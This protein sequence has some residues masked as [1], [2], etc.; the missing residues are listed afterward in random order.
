MNFFIQSSIDLDTSIIRSSVK[1][2]DDLT[3]D[4]YGGDIEHWLTRVLGIYATLAR[5]TNHSQITLANEAAFLLVYE[6]SVRQIRSTLSDEDAITHERFRPNFVV[7]KETNHTYPAAYSEDAW[8]RLSM[9]Y[10]DK[11]IEWTTIGSCQRC[12]V[13]NIDPQTGN[14]RSRLFTRLQTQR[15]PVHQIRAN[16]GILLSLSTNSNTVIVRVGD[17]IQVFQ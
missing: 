11:S 1:I 5:R 6:E 17:R 9:L 2:N 4:I 15:R 10:N 3:C 7:D 8:K 16:F 12:S 14:N 13:V